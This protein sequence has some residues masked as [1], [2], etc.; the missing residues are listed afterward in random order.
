MTTSLH[1]RLADLAGDAPRGG[2][3]PDLWDRAVRH[4]R[5][6]RAGTVAIAAVAVLALVALGALDWWRARPEP[7]PAGSAPALPTRIWMPDKWLPGTD[8]A[9]PLGQLAALQWAVR[10]SWTGDEAG[11]AGISAATGEYRFLDLPDAVLEGPGPVALSPDGRHVAYW[12]TG[13][14]AKSPNSGSGPVVG[15][16]VYD[17]TTGEVVR[18][19]IPTEHGLSVDAVAW[20]DERRV[21]FTYGHWD[22]GDGDPEMDQ[23]SGTTVPGIQVW[24]FQA[25]TEPARLPGSRA[26]DSGIEYAGEGRV[27]T[28]ANGWVVVVGPGGSRLPTLVATGHQEGASAIDRDADRVA[29]PGGAANPSSVL[30]SPLGEGAFRRLAVPGTRKTYRLAGWPD[31]RHVAAVQRVGD[32]Y[33]RTVL[34]LVDVATGEATEVLRYPVGSNGYATHLATDLLRT[35]SVQRPRP[36]DPLDPRKLTGAAVAVVLG[37]L[38]AVVAWRRRV[39][40]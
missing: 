40:A 35:P 25:G 12:F 13:D 18:A 39:R 31:P 20:L 4:H 6:R 10:G 33:D 27:V 9:G 14:T 32:G 24:D 8:D 19:A 28:S 3:V 37:A 22:G 34:R 11:Y 26:V 38:L 29:W 1:D 17:T 16:A 36:P 21:V 23:S 7:A 15:V 30:I 2:P 5:V